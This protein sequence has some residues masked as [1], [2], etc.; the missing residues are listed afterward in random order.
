MSEPR[1]SLYEHVN[2]SGRALE[3]KSATTNLVDKGFNDKCSSIVVHSGVWELFEHVNYGGKTWIVWEGQNYNEWTK[4]GGQNDVISS[5]RPV[6]V[7][8][9]S[10]SGCKVYQHA[11]NKGR[12]IEWVAYIHVNFQ[13]HQLLLQ[14]GNHNI[15]D[16]RGWND[17]ISSMRPIEIDFPTELIVLEYD[18]SAAVINNT[19]KTLQTWTQVNNTDVEQSVKYTEE[20]SVTM[21]L[22]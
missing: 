4:W 7:K 17:T 3:V 9:A 2:T 12:C 13:G 10:R 21:L 11:H 14:E 5:L 1:I 16:I 15:C 8:I 18:T 6:K 19:P 22:K 20:H